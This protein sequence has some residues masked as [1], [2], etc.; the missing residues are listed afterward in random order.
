MLGERV[1]KFLIY[2]D[3]AKLLF[4]EVVLVCPPTC[5]EGEYLFPKPLPTQ[6]VI[7]LFDLCQSVRY[8]MISRSCNFI[9]PATREVDRVFM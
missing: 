4:R 9:S 5:N 1:C 8:K 6:H 3:I 7:K 2:L